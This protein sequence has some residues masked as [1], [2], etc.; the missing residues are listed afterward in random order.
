MLRFE[1][2]GLK[3]HLYTDLLKGG[4]TLLLEKN[5]KNELGVFSRVKSSQESESEVKIVNFNVF[6]AKNGLFEGCVLVQNGCICT[7]CSLKKA[8]FSHKHI[9]IDY[10]NFRFRLLT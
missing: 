6:V 7:E 5:I 1:S 9:E 3:L 10:F 8:I 4:I 2:R